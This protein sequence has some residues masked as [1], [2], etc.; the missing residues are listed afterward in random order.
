MNQSISAFKITMILASVKALFT[1]SFAI[2]S[3]SLI[4]YTKNKWHFDTNVSTAIVGGVFALSALLYFISGYLHEKYISGR[5]LFLLSA[6]LVILSCI[7]LSFENLILLPIGL[8]IF[9]VGEGMGA[10][11]LNNI[12]TRIFQ[13]KDAERESAFFWNYSGLNLG[14]F[15]GLCLSGWFLMSANY[16]AMFVYAAISTAIALFVFLYYWKHFEEAPKTE[17]KRLQ[18]NGTSY[19]IISLCVL[20]IFFMFNHPIYGNKVMLCL[21]LIIF[22]ANFFLMTKRHPTYFYNILSFYF[23]ALVTF[24]FWMIFQI[25]PIALMVFIDKS[26][27]LMI[28]GIK[29]APQ[30][31]ANVNTLSI[32]IG[33]PIVSWVIK[34][35]REKGYTIS[36]YTLFAIAMILMGSSFLILPIGMKLAQAK[37]MSMSW[38]PCLSYCKVLESYALHRLVIRWLEN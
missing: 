13:N 38:M 16:K 12:I 15:I 4:F 5:H 33:S 8:S 28:F 21:G 30:W 7:L 22:I 17:T 32:V 27:D 18:S 2:I 37:L 6:F 26:V 19:A 35:L 23:L 3:F 14:F 1:L 36:D 31:L 10:T 24:I 29:I 25:G 34:S 9:V 11:C 20:A